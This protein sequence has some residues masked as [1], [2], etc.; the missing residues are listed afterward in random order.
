MA[1][2]AGHCAVGG[3]IALSTEHH[4]GDGWV[5]LATCRYRH[6][7]S[8]VETAARD[9]GLVVAAV[10]VEIFRHER[11]EPVPGGLYVLA[12]AAA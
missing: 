10:Q 5:L 2:L 8:H 12:P 1:G 4:D 11:H 6:A 9:S 3:H 7:A